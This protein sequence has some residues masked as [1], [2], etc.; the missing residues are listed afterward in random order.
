MTRS[1]R[2]AVATFALATAGFGFAFT[3]TAAAQERSFDVSGT[4]LQVQGSILTI[5]TADV[6]GREQ[7][8][9]VDVSRLRELQVEVGDPLALTIRSRESDTFLALGLVDESPFV[10]REEF[11]V[12]EEFTVKRDSIQARVGN[13][14]EDDEALAKQDRDHNLRQDEDDDDDDEEEDRRRRRR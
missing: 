12:R 1:V 9:T 11:G 3:G 6:I 8:I 10:N 7:P 13:V 2:R 14:P 4:V 5:L